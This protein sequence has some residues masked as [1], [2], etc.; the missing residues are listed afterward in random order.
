MKKIN[1]VSFVMEVDEYADFDWIGI[2]TD[3]ESVPGIIVRAEDE[4]LDKLPEDYE[5]PRRGRECRFFKPY[6]G[7][8]KE[9]TKD[10]Y[11]YGMQDYK[12]AEGL[13]RG[14]WCF[15]VVH[16]EAEIITGTKKCG[17]VN[18]ISS[19]HLGGIESDSGREYIDEMRG[20]HLAELRSTLASLG[21]TKKQIDKAFED[22][23]EV[24]K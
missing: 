4:F 24:T 21:F 12:R 8:E 10:Y 23:D 22:V 19:G 11:K 18:R 5:L 9:G 7:G 3:D 14:D 17:L 15:M 20:E 1:K 2:Y 13:N 6:A 16:A